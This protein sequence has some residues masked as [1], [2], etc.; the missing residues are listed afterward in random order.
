MSKMFEALIVGALGGNGGGGGGG[1][2]TPT[3]AQ[4][5]A[6][7]SGITE[8]KLLEDETDI[9]N[10]KTKTQGIDSTANNKIKMGNGTTL[11]IGPNPPDNA[12]VGDLWAGG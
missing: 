2:F 4:L 11:F 10:L 3:D 6:M 7:N 5:D 12:E 9:S 1:G 8:E